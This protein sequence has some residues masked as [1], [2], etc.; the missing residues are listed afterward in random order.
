M[1]NN[2]RM[3]ANQI[4]QRLAEIDETLSAGM[5]TVNVDGVTATIDLNHLRRERARMQKQLAEIESGE[6]RSRFRPIQL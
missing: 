5:T 3:N 2:G 1:S 6:T 4:R